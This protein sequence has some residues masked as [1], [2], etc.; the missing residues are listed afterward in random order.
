M[1]ARLATIL[2]AT[3]GYICFLAGRQFEATAAGGAKPSPHTGDQPFSQRSC[4]LCQ[5]CPPQPSCVAC[6][7]CPPPP[8]CGKS[9]VGR[10]G[11]PT[12]STQ[13]GKSQNEQNYDEEYWTSQKS[14][15]QFAGLYKGDL[16]RHLFPKKHLESVL[17]FGSA[18]GY[19]VSKL[20]A[21]LKAGVEVSQ[22][23]RAHAQK[24]NPEARYYERLDEVATPAGGF[25]VIYTTSVIEHVDCPLCMLR[26]MRTMLQPGGRLIVGIKNDGAD[27]AQVRWHRGDRNHHIYTWNELLLGNLIQ[28]AGFHVCDVKGAYSAWHGG[29]NMFKAYEA[30]KFQWC[31]QG[32]RAGK[33]ANVYNIWAVA[34]LDAAKC[35]NA[36]KALS[37]VAS[38]ANLGG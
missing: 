13:K 35:G 16:L 18:G 29:A 8:A 17:E 38:C 5:A 15:N 10:G 33:D 6:S 4:P 23:A 26:Q 9:A 2:I 19:I 20:P 11:A 7:P 32:L 24:Q 37:D 14:A 28:S 21:S 1:Q 25:E 30:N 3:M 31:V 22:F 34:T 12:P 36:K 27:P